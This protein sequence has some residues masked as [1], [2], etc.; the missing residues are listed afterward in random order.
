VEDCSTSDIPVYTWPCAACSTT[1]PIPSVANVIASPSNPT[2]QEYAID[3]NTPTYYFQKFDSY[4]C[5]G[6]CQAYHYYEVYNDLTGVI[7]S[8]VK[9][10]FSIV[11]ETSAKVDTATVTSKLT[12]AYYDF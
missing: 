3:G 8:T 11:R 12:E 4:V 2:Y 1:T 7:S 6:A 5:S 9:A 10:S